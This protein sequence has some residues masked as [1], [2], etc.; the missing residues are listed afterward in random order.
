[1]A[2]L[3]LFPARVQFVDSTGRLTPEAY[4]ALNMLFER[5][6]GTFGDQGVDVFA[7][8]FGGT[9]S[10]G[11]PMQMDSIMQ[12]AGEFPL[13][14]PEI[15]QMAELS[16]IDSFSVMQPSGLAQYDIDRFPVRLMSYTVATLPAAGTLG[17]LA[18]VTDALAPAFLTIV[19]GGGAVKSPVFDDG[20]NWVAF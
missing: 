5:T 10:D 7:D 20:T 9:A 19:V 4:R 18:C 2:T 13:T 11:A 16:L 12:P 6:G 3:N 17:R 8:I 1:M 14:T 15:N